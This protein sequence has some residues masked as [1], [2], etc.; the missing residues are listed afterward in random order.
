MK[1]HYFGG[2]GEFSIP[3]YQYNRIIAGKNAQWK[4]APDLGREEGCMFIEPVTAPSAKITDAP[5]LEY[6]IYL[7]EDGDLTVALGILPTQDINPA[8]GLRMAIAVDD[9]MPH[10]VDMRKG[11]HNEF[12]EYTPQI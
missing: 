2:A 9:E 12:R 8:R 4:F 11:M 5:C 10:V 1:G 6:D 3:A 7:P